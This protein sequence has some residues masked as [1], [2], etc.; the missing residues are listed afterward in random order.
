MDYIQV[1]ERVKRINPRFYQDDAF[2]GQSAMLSKINSV[3]RFVQS[4]FDSILSIT[5]NFGYEIPIRCDV[6]QYLSSIGLE[7]NKCIATVKSA[8]S[9]YGRYNNKLWIEDYWRVL[10]EEVRKNIGT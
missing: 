5:E 4:D 2:D 7:S 6:K 3:K 8:N 1:V 9:Q 10:I